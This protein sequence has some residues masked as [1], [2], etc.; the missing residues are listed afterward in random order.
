M[1]IQEV[2]DKVI[3][4]GYYT[5]NAPLMCFSL[6][7]ASFNGV[8]SLEERSFAHDEIKKY[9]GAFGSLGGLLCNNKLPYCFQDRLSIYK[10]WANR[11]V[12]FKGE[13]R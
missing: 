6:T 10:D 2:F 9:L 8:I 11:P 13:K 4:A 1:N 12:L 7:K 5:E 3:E